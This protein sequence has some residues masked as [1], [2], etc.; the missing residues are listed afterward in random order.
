[1]VKYYGRARQRIGSVNTNQIGLNMSGCPSKVGR[2]G[3]LSRYIARRSQCNQKYCGPVYYHGVLW[4][5]NAGRCVAKAP[6][7]QSFNSGVGH[8]S[9]PRFACGNTCS[10]D[11]TLEAA[12]KIIF[13]Y[14]KNKFKLTSSTSI[15]YEPAL[16]GVKETIESDLGELYSDLDPIQHL[17]PGNFYFDQAPPTVKKAIVSVNSRDLTFKIKGNLRKHIVGLVS[18]RDIYPLHKAGFGILLKISPSLKITAY[19]DTTEK[20]VCFILDS[21]QWWAITTENRTGSIDQFCTV[22][23]ETMDWLSVPEF[24]L[25]PGITH[26]PKADLLG[27]TYNYPSSEVM[28]IT[29]KNIVIYWLMPESDLVDKTNADPD[30]N[31]PNLKEWAKYNQY[32]YPGNI[33]RTEHTVDADGNY[34][35]YIVHPC[36]P[37]NCQIKNIN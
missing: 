13:E 14:F 36:Y 18:N 11:L 17:E 24:N 33:Y 7:G 2:Q 25:K 29:D 4:S 32:D 27:P 35:Y 31:Y 6:R 37:V 34:M 5:W 16:V 12:F 28:Y 21:H 26:I 19:G 30:S 15:L 10:T 1:M 9:T 3:Y 22:I 8:K 20:D 23:S